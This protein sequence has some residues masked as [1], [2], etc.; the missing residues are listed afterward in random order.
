[1]W[2]LKTQQ[3]LLVSKPYIDKLEQ[4]AKLLIKYLLDLSQ[5]PTIGF[6]R[7]APT[8]EPRLRSRPEKVVAISAPGPD[9]LTVA[10]QLKR[11]SPDKIVNR[12]NDINTPLE[13][14]ISMIKTSRRVYKPKIDEKA[15]TNLIYSR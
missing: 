7:K 2:T 6:K 13:K 15:I 8:G 14:I 1:M 11:S 5:L 12:N 4:R 10:K 9:L 3:I